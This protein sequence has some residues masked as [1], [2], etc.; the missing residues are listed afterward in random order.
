MKQTP[1]R[2]SDAKLERFLLG[3]LD[4]Q[5]MEEVRRISDSDA[6]VKTRLAA[7]RASGTEILA[8]YPPED[9]IP[10]IRARAVA[11]RPSP[12]MGRVGSASAAKGVLRSLWSF[13]IAGPA[14]AALAI[15]I[16][17]LT[18]PG[19]IKTA[20]SS[21][22]DTVPD[23]VRLKGSESGLVIFRKSRSGSELLPPQAFARPGDT[24]QVFYH[25]RK[26]AYGMVFSLD[27]SG[28]LTLHYPESEGPA[29][30]LRMGDM[31]PLPHAFRLDKAPRFE[32][33]FLLTSEQP[34][35]TASLLA[36]I[37]GAYPPGQALTDTPDTL[38]GLASGFRQYPY[39]IN[40]E[41]PRKPGMR[42]DAA[43]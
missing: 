27:G 22:Q 12:A 2:I 24:L 21:I 14:F 30:A 11:S 15:G 8:A 28:N 32:R 18:Y 10:A 6:E 9:L 41:A 25:S 33:F 19:R 7:L 42:K 20:Q 31:L 38:T 23:T 1:T 4:P 40:K 39:T 35:A 16:G 34:F 36:L 37:R 5:S 29:A 13:R 26:E 43:P 3:E 17:L